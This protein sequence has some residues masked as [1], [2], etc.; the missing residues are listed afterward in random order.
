MLQNTNERA[1]HR[2]HH[3]AAVR[4][5]VRDRVDAET[6]QYFSGLER[7]SWAILSNSEEFAGR[8][9]RS[10]VSRGALLARTARVG[11]PRLHEERVTARR[12]PNAL[13]AIVDDDPWACEG[14]NGFVVSL[15]YAGVPFRSAEEYLKS[16][17]KQRTRCLI[18]DVH[19][20][21][22]SGPE[23]QA[24]L[25]ADGYRTPIIFVTAKLEEHVRDRVMKAGAF[26]YLV[27][28]CN[29]ATLLNCLERAV[30]G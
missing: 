25:L 21:G 23:L 19:L 18:L 26:G 8:L 15:G 12:A 10:C 22:M 16:E 2:L 5:L 17:L 24:R 9:Q 3:A 27:K 4:E 1:A 7:R 20:G 28:P 14:M 6:R 11:A 30:G 29:E 13:I